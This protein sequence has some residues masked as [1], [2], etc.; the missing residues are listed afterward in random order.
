LIRDNSDGPAA[1]ARVSAKQ[2]FAIL[3]AIFLEFARVHHARDNF[4][5]V[6]LFSRIARK[7]S[8]NVFAGIQ[9]FALISRG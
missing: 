7:D 4:P 2:S 9:R 1:D 3:S 8:V 6:V 5:H